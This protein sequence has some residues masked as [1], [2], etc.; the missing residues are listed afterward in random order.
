MGTEQK[1]T[2]EIIIP[3]IPP[4]L[5]KVHGYIKKSGIYNEYLRKKKLKNKRTKGIRKEIKE[6]NYNLG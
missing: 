1:T 2:V 6:I 3:L 4:T 5:Q